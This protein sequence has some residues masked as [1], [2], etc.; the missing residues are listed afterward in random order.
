[1]SGGVVHETGRGVGG[2]G[3]GREVEIIRLLKGAVG[4]AGGEDGVGYT[5]GQ[6]L[7]ST[8]GI[9]RAAVWKHM[10]A[11]RKAG[12]SIEA[13]PSKGYRL[14][15]P[16][17]YNAIEVASGLSTGFVGRNLHFFESVDSTNRKAFEL[18]R[19]GAPEGTSVIADEQ[20]AGHGRMGRSWVSPAGVNIYTSILLRPD[21]PPQRAGELTFVAAVA[22]AEAVSR[23]SPARPEVK[24]PNDIL[25]GGRKV[26]G[27]LLEMDSETDH[28]HFVVA[29]VGIN[30]NMPA[31]AL[32]PEVRER[33]TSLAGKGGAAVDRCELLRELY[34]KLEKWYKVYITE[35]FE[36]VAEA[37]KGYFSSE[38]KPVRVEAFGRSIEGICLGIDP[39]GALLVRTAAGSVERVVSGDMAAVGR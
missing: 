30:V 13:S 9:S 23:F 2:V 24:W 10:E 33:A 19:R 20:R 22:A 7:S 11:L 1:M 15:G 18:G 39:G 31:R 21:I 29:G 8:L 12:F 36:R 5:S 37:W 4:A 32:P 34:S 3:G 38:G 25:I 35:G 6:L 14:A 17:P 28:V 26:A 27:I 16:L